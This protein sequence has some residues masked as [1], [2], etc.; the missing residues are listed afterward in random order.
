[1]SFVRD[2]FNVEPDIIPHSEQDE[3]L[4]IKFDSGMNDEGLNSIADWKLP[5]VRH[6]TADTAHRT[7]NVA[8]LLQI[9]DAQRAVWLQG[10]V[11]G[12]WCVME[13]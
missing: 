8:L 4:E 13:D 2:P 6:G 9:V 3:F 7:G 12:R 10:R 11:R 1:M 5:P